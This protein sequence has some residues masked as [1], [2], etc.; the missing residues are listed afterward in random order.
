MDPAKWCAIGE[1]CSHLQFMA[2]DKSVADIGQ[3]SDQNERLQNA[4]A[5][6]AQTSRANQKMNA[7]LEKREVEDAENRFSSVR[8]VHE[9]L[10]QRQQFSV[11]RFAKLEKE[12]EDTKIELLK[13]KAEIRRLETEQDC[14]TDDLIEALVTDAKRVAKAEALE[15]VAGERKAMAEDRKSLLRVSRSLEDNLVAMRSVTAANAAEM[16]KL[17]A[18]SD[19]S[20][21]C[22]QA[23]WQALLGSPVPEAIAHQP[24][25]CCFAL[26]FWKVGALQKQKIKGV[27]TEGVE[28]A[29]HSHALKV[30]GDDR[31]KS[32]ELGMVPVVGG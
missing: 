21:S 23:Y 25:T 17:L 7:R 18:D 10:S 1:D 28:A 22:W 14:K 6:I 2:R 11:A 24:E 8:P 5:Q 32:G 12:L 20:P 16:D 15:E 13:A 4:I 3:E 9:D 30:G 26:R 27:T 29:H 31:G 19:E